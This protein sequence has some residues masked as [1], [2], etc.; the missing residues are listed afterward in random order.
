M[1][2]TANKHKPAE[3]LLLATPLGLH[4]SGLTGSEFVV[5][6]PFAAC[7]LCGALYQHADDRLTKEFLDRGVLIEHYNHLSKESYFTGS[8]QAVLLLEES[9][10]RRR[11]WRELHERRYHTTAEINNFAKT[12][13]ALTPEAANKLAPYGITPLGKLHEEIDA[14]LLDAPRAPIVDIEQ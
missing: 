1:A 13:Y 5:E 11:R 8:G 7:R 12:G 4:D 2:I 6:A 9:T 14:A 10:A 3:P